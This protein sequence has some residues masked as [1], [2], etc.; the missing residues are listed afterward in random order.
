[1]KYKESG[2]KTNLYANFY[3]TKK[4][5]SDPISVRIDV[6]VESSSDEESILQNRYSFLPLNFHERP[7]CSR[8]SVAK[9]HVR[10]ETWLFCWFLAAI[11]FLSKVWIFDTN[12]SHS[13]WKSLHKIW[14]QTN[15][16]ISR[17]L[18]KEKQY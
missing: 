9:P 16:N 11:H 5:A 8:F 15:D 14:K 2:M 7:R 1:M 6:L 13:N 17:E 18:I 10:A 12:F 4:T 3:S